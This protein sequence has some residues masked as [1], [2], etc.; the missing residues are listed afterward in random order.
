MSKPTETKTP[1]GSGESDPRVP[2]EQ[3]ATRLKAA[4]EQLVLAAL[5]ARELA[6]S[7]DEFRLLV[8]SVK[9][10]AIITLDRAGCVR[11]WNSGA[12]R[13][14]G[15]DADDIVGR[16]FS[17]FYAPEDVASGACDHDIALAS[18]EGH[19]EVEGVRVRRDGS[20]FLASFVMTALR[21]AADELVGFGVVT[22]DL[23]D[24]VRMDEARIELARV[25][26]AERMKDEFLAIMGHELR[27]P[28]APMVTAVHLLKSRGDA[29]IDRELAVLDRQLHH[30][31]R[32]VD[33]LLDV[34]RSRQGKLSLS[35]GPTEISTVLTNVIEM[36]MPLLEGAHHHLELDV[37]ATGLAILR[38]RRKYSR[39]S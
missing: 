32:L 19:G 5:R 34:S 28:L 25:A 2:A 18:R 3:T 11:T 9:E 26:Q 21:N 20:H 35:T 12:V 33:D 13:M 23:T 1:Q 38:E 27:N 14:L 31:M 7:A 29:K 15:Y 37:A 16:H 8:D 17:T 10:Y 4:N 6:E 24:R 22:R 36:V 30:M 39:T